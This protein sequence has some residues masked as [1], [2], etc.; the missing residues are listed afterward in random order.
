MELQKIKE[1][2]AKKPLVNDAFD[3]SF[4]KKTHKEEFDTETDDEFELSDDEECVSTVSTIGIDEQLR[5]SILRS[6]D[7]RIM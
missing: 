1:R 3:A 5:E 4:E 7:Y 6:R 2:L